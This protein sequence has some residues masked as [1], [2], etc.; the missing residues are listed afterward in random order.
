MS[1]LTLILDR[2]AYHYLGSAFDYEYTEDRFGDHEITVGE[3]RRYAGIVQ[4][5]DIKQWIILISPLLESHRGIAHRV[6][7]SLHTNPRDGT[8]IL[9]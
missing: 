4:D 2:S 9:A 7:C 3:F 6:K 8:S 1:L 5:K